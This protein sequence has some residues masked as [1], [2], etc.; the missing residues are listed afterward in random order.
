VIFNEV[1]F[2]LLFLAPSVLLFHGAARLP[3]ARALRL[4]SWI[5]ALFGGAFFTY[6]GY[7]HFGGL[8]GAAAVLIF[9]AELLVSRWY[10]RSSF[11]CVV[12]IVQAVLILVA[13]K[14][15]SFFSG[16]VADV[17]EAFGL[18]RPDVLP[19]V[20]IPLGL[21]FFTFEFIHV[22]ADVRSGKLERPPLDRYAAFIFFF[23]TMVAGPI[24]RYQ[25]FGPQLDTARFDPALASRGVT[26]ILAGLAK[27]HV[28]ADTFSLFSDRLTSGAV[29]SASAS[30]IF[31]WVLA[32]GMKIYFD[33]SGY[34]DIAIGSAYLFGIHV[35]ENFN[36]PYT[37]PNIREF[38]R[39]WH[40]SLGRWIF[41]YVYAPLGGSRHGKWRTSV[42]LLLAFAISGLWH[43]AAYNFLLWGL[44]HGVCL[45]VHQLFGLW[46]NRPTGRAWTL[47]STVVTFV[48]VTFGWALFCMDLSHFKAA[49]AR[50][51]SADSW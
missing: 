8:W 17:G 45:V 16:V 51:L 23:P 26:R 13:F 33:F 27:K 3:V 20:V 12:G 1:S 49:G 5:L 39:R 22:A 25:D 14:Y 32:Y 30:E 9:V 24:K 37:S 28:L 40:I 43:G 29:A 44:W 41:D 35:P 18:D 10:A 2:F 19:K 42:N 50:V 46:P 6:Y 21:S 4:R 31:A 15:S 11:M 7:L 36:W 38:W 47:F 48:A 34:S